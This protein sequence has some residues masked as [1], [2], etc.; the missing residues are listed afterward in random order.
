M[1]R[2]IICLLIALCSLTASG[3]MVKS[4]DCIPVSLAMQSKLYGIGGASFAEMYWVYMWD[5]PI[6]TFDKEFCLLEKK[7]VETGDVEYDALYVRHFNDQ[8]ALSFYRYPFYREGGCPFLL[9]ETAEHGIMYAQTIGTSSASFIEFNKDNLFCNSYKLDYN[10]KTL[11]KLKTGGQDYYYARFVD[12]FDANRIVEFSDKGFTSNEIIGSNRQIRPDN[13]WEVAY[14]LNGDVSIVNNKTNYISLTWEYDKSYIQYRKE[15]LKNKETAPEIDIHGIRYA[16]LDAAGRWTKE[17][18]Y[19][20]DVVENKMVPA[21]IIKRT[22]VP[23]DQFEKYKNASFNPIR[24]AEQEKPKEEQKS[25]NSTRHVDIEPTF[26]GGDAST[27]DL[28]VNEHIQYPEKA[29]EN[30]ITGLVYVKFFIEKDGTVSNV[31]VVRSVS[32]ELDEEAVRVVSSSPQWT[33][34]YYKGEPVRTTYTV[35]VVF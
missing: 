22:F 7:N 28:W 3:Q 15:T 16:D 10:S 32:P 33:P 30:S 11:S 24:F 35:T 29:Q 34:A 27:F 12:L 4:G 5:V 13:P 31:S 9:M 18:L 19:D 8:P 25:G 20:Y 26:N 23:I 21:L 14:N 17:T 2:V 6:S 1:K